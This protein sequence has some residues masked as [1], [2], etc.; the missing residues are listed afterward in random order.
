MKCIVCKSSLVDTKSNVLFKCV[1]CGLGVT[2]R[3]VIQSYTNYHRDKTYLQE[4]EQFSNILKKRAELILRFKRA[5]KVLDIGSSTG[6]LLSLLKNKRWVVE[7][8]EPSKKAAEFAQNRGIPTQVSTFEIAKLEP[9]SYDA[10]IL[11]HVFEHLGNP[12][13]ILSKV[14]NLLKREGIVFIDVPNFGGIKAR[15]KVENWEY[16]LPNEH[17]W[18][19]TKESLSRLLRQSGFEIIY[20]ET[21]SGIWDYGNPLLEIWQ[22]LTGFK[23]RFFKNIFFLVPDYFVSILGVG[24]GLTVVGRKK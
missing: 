12:D 22:S 18:H 7:G 6:L 4:T 3:K 17:K 23:R 10:I 2:K 20:S 24:S 1:N 14:Y 13:A 19:F 15:I 11:N 21:R 8:I 9:N 16:S 5:G